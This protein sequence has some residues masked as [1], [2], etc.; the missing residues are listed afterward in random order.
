MDKRAYLPMERLVAVE[1]ERTTEEEFRMLLAPGEQPPEEGAP[2]VAQG[3]G[4]EGPRI[5]A[6]AWAA[7]AGTVA[8]GGGA[9]YFGGRARLA[10]LYLR[11]TYQADRNLYQGTRVQALEG[12]RSAVIANVLFGVGGVLLG[13]AVTLTV[14]ENSHESAHP[15]PAVQVT[16]AATPGGAALL[17]DGRF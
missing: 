16:P 14:L 12:Q 2:K 5:P 7:Y 17:L 10:E 1:P 9:I 6:G 3:A 11:S 13:T 8:A 4:A 15:A